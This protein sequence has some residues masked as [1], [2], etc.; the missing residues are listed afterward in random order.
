MSLAASLAASLETLLLPTIEMMGSTTLNKRQLG[1]RQ[2]QSLHIWTPLLCAKDPWKTLSDR[3]ARA[4]TSSLKPSGTRKNKCS[5]YSKLQSVSSKH[6]RQQQ[7]DDWSHGA[8]H[9]RARG[10][11]RYR[12]NLALGSCRVN[13]SKRGPTDQ[14]RGL[15]TK[16]LGIQP[17]SSSN[18]FCFLIC[19]DETPGK[20]PNRPPL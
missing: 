19:W 6:I 17:S 2:F 9:N 3:S 13:S 1:R 11:R 10:G 4:L 18:K 7:R 12:A 15:I 5:L 16:R 20:H 8:H 14:P